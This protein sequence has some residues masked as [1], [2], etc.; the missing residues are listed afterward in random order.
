V[1]IRYPSA[2]IGV[3]VSPGTNT[4]TTAPNGDKVATF[5]V[6]GSLVLTS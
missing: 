6:S 1:V 3:S 5:T 4:I 2:A